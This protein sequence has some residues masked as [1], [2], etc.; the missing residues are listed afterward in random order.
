VPFKGPYPTIYSGHATGM[1]ISGPNWHKLGTN[2]MEPVSSSVGSIVNSGTIAA[3]TSI[4][5]SES[6]I[7][8][9]VVDSGT[10]NATSQ[11]IPIDSASEILAANIAIEIAGLTFTGGVTNFGKVAGSAGIVIATARPVSISWPEALSQQRTAT[12]ARW[13]PRRKSSRC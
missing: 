3:K 13:S 7:V 2:G 5:L 11:G 10:I 4:A 6:I 1:V 12:A 8:G 9:A